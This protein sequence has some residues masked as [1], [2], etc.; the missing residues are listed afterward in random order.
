M[1]FLFMAAMLSIV[2][3]VAVIMATVCGGISGW[4]VGWFFGDTILGILAQIGISNV[5]MFQVGAFLGFIASFF[6]K[7][8]KIKNENEY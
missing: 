2:F 6:S 8:L 7:S 3:I 1:R 5:S 4:I